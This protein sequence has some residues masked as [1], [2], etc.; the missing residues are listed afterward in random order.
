MVFYYCVILST[1]YQLGMLGLGLHAKIF[2][3]G[4]QAH[5]CAT[6]ALVLALALQLEALALPPKALLCDI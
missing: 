5:S 2:D 4:L 1:D 3:L 6:L